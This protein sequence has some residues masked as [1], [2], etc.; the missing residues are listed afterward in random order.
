MA[1]FVC[2]RKNKKKKWMTRKNATDIGQIDILKKSV[3]LHRST[4]SALPHI[5][6]RCG[7]F[8]SAFALKEESF[9][10]IALLYTSAMLHS[11]HFTAVVM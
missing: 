8:N 10:V 5:R 2:F 11:V 1:V 6:D 4:I 7:L 3:L 9:F